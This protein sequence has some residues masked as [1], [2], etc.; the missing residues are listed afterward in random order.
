MHPN[1]DPNENG[2]SYA[3]P[4][5]TE[6]DI[7]HKIV[8]A[9]FH[10]FPNTTLTVCCLQLANGYTVTGESACVSPANFD[11]ALGEQLARTDAVRKV[12]ALEGYLLREQ[13]H[14][15]PPLFD[16]G[17]LTDADRA[18]LANMRGAEDA[19]P[20][21]DATVY[22]QPFLEPPVLGERPAA[23]DREE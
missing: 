20:G 3:A 6:R 4:R 23:I 22:G 14:A 21:S 13:L 9:Q 12:W 5:L 11:Q 17:P 15:T 10:R 8:A 2:S 16:S 18:A 19:V 7:E 1:L